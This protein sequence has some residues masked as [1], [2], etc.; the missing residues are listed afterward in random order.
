VVPTSGLFSH[1]MI[2][3]VITIYFAMVSPVNIVK[4]DA[5]C[6]Y[7]SLFPDCST[8][9]KTGVLCENVMLI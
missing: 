1:T 4:A 9:G 3:L 8:V 5:D 6:V 2:S 7:I